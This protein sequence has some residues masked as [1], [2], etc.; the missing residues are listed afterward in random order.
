MSTVTF[1]SAIER[2]VNSSEYRQAVA[3]GKCSLKDDFE[4]T[5]AELDSLV[6]VG[7][8]SGWIGAAAATPPCCCCCCV[9]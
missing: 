6:L 1:Q 2:L 8:C 5:D 7:K 4:L 9:H 3:A